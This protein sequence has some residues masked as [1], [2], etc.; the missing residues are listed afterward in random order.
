MDAIRLIGLTVTGCHGALEEERSRAQPFRVDVELGVD[1][2][3]PGQSDDLADTVDYGTLTETLAR[4]VRTEHHSLLE[5]LATRLADACLTDR[6][7]RSVT[8]EVT[9]LRPPVPE[10]MEAASVRVTRP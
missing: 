5:R 1:L 2:Q 10:V 9:K 7:V 4:I 6:R 8:V 3:L